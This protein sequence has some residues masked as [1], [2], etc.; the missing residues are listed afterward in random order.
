MRNFLVSRHPNETVGR[1]VALFRWW[2]LGRDDGDY[3]TGIQ[4]ADEIHRSSLCTQPKTY[5]SL[6]V[7]RCLDDFFPKLDFRSWPSTRAINTTPVL[8]WQWFPSSMWRCYLV[9]KGYRW[10]DNSS[11]WGTVLG[12][13]FLY[14]VSAS[15][16]SCSDEY[17]RVKPSLRHKQS[18]RGS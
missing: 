15:C 13:S 7:T 11:L 17:A 3:M 14:C 6:H 4:G 2:I 1:S 10:E 5:S 9:I 16:Q 18:R 8:D 12:L